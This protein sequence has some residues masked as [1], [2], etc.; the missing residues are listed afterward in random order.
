MYKQLDIFCYGPTTLG[1]VQDNRHLALIGRILYVG[2][3]KFSSVRE[4][5]YDGHGRRASVV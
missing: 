3:V 4:I 5:V 1:A 2:V